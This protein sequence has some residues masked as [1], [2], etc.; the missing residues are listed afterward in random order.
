MALTLLFSLSALAEETSPWI[1]LHKGMAP[2]AKETQV[3]P[4]R[5]SDVFRPEMQIYYPKGWKKTDKRPAVCIFPG[6]SYAIESIVPEGSDVAKWLNE[7]GIVAAVVKYRVTRGP[8]LDCVYPAPLLDARKALRLLRQNATQYGINPKAIGVIGFSAGGHLASMATT[9]WDKSFEEEKSP[10]S[11]AQVS[12][13]PD[14]S[15]LIYPVISMQADIR[16]DGSR[17]RLFRKALSPEQ[18]MEFSA[19]K[20]VTR[21]TPPLFLVHAEDDFVKIANSERMEAA[22]KAHGVPVHFARYPKGGHGYGVEK[23]NNPTDAW[24]E[25]AATWLKSK[26]WEKKT[27]APKKP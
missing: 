9:K 18:E 10:E 20:Q 6:G 12:A 1:P 26:P 4:L 23:R 19:D 8:S 16:H 22:A 15:L 24:P 27:T 3:D 11:L 14:F 21:N 2:E 5:I 17:E 13:R 7:Q 25:E